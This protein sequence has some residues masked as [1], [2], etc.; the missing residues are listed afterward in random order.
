MKDDGWYKAGLKLL[1]YLVRCARE[2]RT[3]TYSQAAKA[4]GYKGPRPMYAVCGSIRDRICRKRG[5]PWINV[6]VV[7]KTTGMPGGSFTPSGTKG[8]SKKRRENEWN[9]RRDEVLAYE[10]W[11]ELLRELNIEPMER[12]IQPPK[13]LNEEACA[14]TRAEAKRY[15]RGG[16]GEQPRHKRMKAYILKHP[17]VLK[18][19]GRAKPEHEFPSGDLCDV[20]VRLRKGGYAVVEVKVG[21]VDGELWKGIYQ[22]VKYKALKR[23]EMTHH[24]EAGDVKAFLVAYSIP[25]YISKYAE[26]V[27]IESVSIE[28]ITV[29]AIMRS[30][31]RI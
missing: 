17:E 13:K 6:L 10:G 20:L 28:E 4:I 9:R 11:D 1:P 22:A 27:G 21:D 23:A 31:E 2:R 24:N 29:K 16:I 8:W 14:V 30:D 25:G 18:I 5:L 7:S 19:K 3:M 26:Q 15:S 12:R